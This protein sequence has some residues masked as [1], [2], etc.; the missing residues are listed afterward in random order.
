MKI[1]ISGGGTGG[2]IF[3]AIAI[4]DEIK[5]QRP[6]TEIL[7]VGAE[8]KMEMERV[9]KAGYEIVGLPV[10]G[11]QRKFT[12]KNLLFPFKLANSLIKA[13]TV[14]RKFKPDVVVGVGGYASGPILEMGMRLG[15]KGVI[16][17]QNSY[18]GVTNKILGRKVHKVCVAYEG[19]DA[20]FTKNKIVLTGNP[21]RADISA[22]TISPEHAKIDLGFDPNKKLILLIGGS[23][24][25]K[26][27]NEAMREATDFL[28]NR[29]DVQVFWQCGKIYIDEYSVSETAKLENVKISA[30]VDDMKMAYTA[31]DIVISRAGALSISELCLVAK[32]CIF[33]PSPNV[34]EDH[35]TKNA[36][37][38]VNK[39]AAVL[40][41]DIDA[42]SD[43]LIKTIEILDNSAKMS[44]LA[45]NIAK[46]G[47]PN[48]A[49]EIV[50][51]IFS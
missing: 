7:F 50:A 29:N 21:V 14:I 38:L 26:T 19:M 43:L 2:H 34:S 32:P 11:F 51:E 10:V 42:K 4:A 27:L 45:Q 18:A 20:F 41:K 16:Q 17:E 1:I 37:A 23:L 44:Q 30:F 3:P 22:V 25:A 46:L 48:A 8:G 49:K 28:K 24:G 5:R 40:V 12:L 13:I 9:P 6:D 35:Q 31:A 39:E 47:K 33:V 15:V 36:M